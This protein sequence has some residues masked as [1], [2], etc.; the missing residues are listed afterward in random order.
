MLQYALTHFEAYLLVLVRVIAFIGASPL[1]SIRI[2]P[3]IA[4]IGLAAFVALLVVPTISTTIPSAF[5]NPGEYILLILK[6]SVIGLLLGFVATMFFS[7]VTIGGQ[8]FDVQVGFSSATLFD[9]Q[10]GVSSGI[11]GTFQSILFTFYF[12]G[13]AGLDGFVGLIMSSYHFVPLGH[14][15]LKAGFSDYLTHLLGVVTVIAIQ[16]IAPLLVALLLTDTTFALLSRAVPQMNVYVVGSPAKLFV[17]IALAAL[18]M[19][20]VVYVFN[21]LFMT[22]FQQLNGLTQWLGG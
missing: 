5:V 10:S 7:V 11:T 4:K 19:P 6:E 9:P 18:A 8:I 14:L 1:L 22:L 2:W 16:L 3:T 15:V 12:L 21:Q 13:N 17:G 20:A